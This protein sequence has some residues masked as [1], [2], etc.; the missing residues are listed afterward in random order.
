MSA[1]R[2]QE[3]ST[4]PPRLP[5]VLLAEPATTKF[6]W[7]Y[8]RDQ[9][10]VRYATRRLAEATGSNWMVVAEALMRLRKL[11]LLEDLE[12]PQLKR[13]PTFRILDEPST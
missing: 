13:K 2:Q 10:V 7:A 5:E 6:L 1:K 3:P 8:L 4:S 9:G 12:P 11:G